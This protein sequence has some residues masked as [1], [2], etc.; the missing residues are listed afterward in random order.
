MS[1]LAVLFILWL[2]FRP[3]PEIKLFLYETQAAAG[4]SVPMKLHNGSLFLECLINDKPALVKVDTGANICVFDLDKLDAFG[5]GKTGESRRVRLAGDVSVVSWSLEPFTIDFPS[6][7]VK[8]HVTLADS[9]PGSPER[10]FDYDCLLGGDFLS[11]IGA[12]IDYPG[13]KLVF[14]C[15]ERVDVEL[16]E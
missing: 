16:E 1:V 6:I 12:Q 13:L 9:N 4:R 8:A 15:K 3:K 11:A 14:Q 10:G 7:G 5:I 2:E